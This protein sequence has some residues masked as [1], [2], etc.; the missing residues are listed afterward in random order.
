MLLIYALLNK[1]QDEADVSGLLLG[2]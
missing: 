1:M 2:A